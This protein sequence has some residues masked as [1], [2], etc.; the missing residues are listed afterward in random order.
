MR[1]IAPGVYQIKV[2]LPCDPEV[3]ESNLGYT[4]VYLIE[5]HDGWTMID[6]GGNTPEGL[7]ALDTQFHAAGAQWEDVR[8]L[9]VTHFHAD[10]LGLASAVRERSKAKLIMHEL[11]AP[12][13][14]LKRWAGSLD[15]RANALVDAL[16]AQGMPRDAVQQMGPPARMQ[17]ILNMADADVLVNGNHVLRRD[18]VELHIL[19][20]PG[21]TPGHISVYYPAQKLLFSGDHLLPRIT[22]NIPYFPIVGGNPLGD[23][24]RSLDKLESV[25]VDWVLPPHEGTFRNLQKRLAELRRHHD[26]RLRETL[27]AVRDGPRT[28]WQI[29]SKIRWRVGTW[30]EMA[31]RT[32]QFALMETLAHIRHL[33]EQGKLRETQRDGVVYYGLVEASKPLKR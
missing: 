27:A 11:D 9:I 6:S 24:L 8:D 23:Y 3:P 5:G 12:S 2:P 21:H 13:A 7:E 18:G 26:R 22:P 33:V 30:A 1:K 28:A 19:W 32:R 10:H 4:L 29:A 14:L 16:V 31:S 15:E 20:T 17:A 25:S